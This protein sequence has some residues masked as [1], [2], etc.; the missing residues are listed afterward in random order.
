MAIFISKP[1]NLGPHGS[2][3]GLF[4]TAVVSRVGYCLHLGIPVLPFDS[5]SLRVGV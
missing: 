2:V 4:P 5:D 1:I 3:L